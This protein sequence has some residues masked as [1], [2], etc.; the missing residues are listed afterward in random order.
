V[1]DRRV[2][3]L[4]R[5]QFVRVAGAFLA[6]P[7]VLGSNI[8]AP[9][10]A[11]APVDYMTNKEVFDL[12]FEKHYWNMGKIIKYP[13]DIP[14]GKDQESET[15]VSYKFNY[16]KVERYIE[17]DYLTLH[18]HEFKSEESKVQGGI[19][20]LLGASLDRNIVVYDSDAEK[21]ELS[22]RLIS[23]IKIVHSRTSG[24][25]MDVLLVDKQITKIENIK[26]EKDTT[27]SGVKIIRCDIFDSKFLRGVED[28]R[29]PEGKKSMVI[30]L[31][32][33]ANTSINART[34]GFINVEIDGKNAIAILDNKQ[35][36]MGVI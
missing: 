22:K 4:N 6:T 33:K 12:V 3:S 23:L 5:R 7:Y 27:Y 32:L 35:L 15:N 29:I 19:D 2:S 24:R 17:G 16:N 25:K 20:C 36:S 9:V 8:A 34:G 26:I 28:G 18:P 31:S 14:W 21:G 10:K 30:G 11:S 1:E 13:L